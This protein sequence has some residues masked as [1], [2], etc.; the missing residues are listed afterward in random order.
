M[1]RTCCKIDCEKPAEVEMFAQTGDPYD[2]TD[3]CLD[4]IGELLGSVHADREW[5]SYSTL[6]NPL[7]AVP[8]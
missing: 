7:V 5:G 8:A 2:Y 4:H 6:I 1:E 3:A